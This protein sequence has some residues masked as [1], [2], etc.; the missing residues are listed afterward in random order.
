[1]H[2]IFTYFVHAMH[3]MEP[4]TI[5]IIDTDVV[6]YK[7]LPEAWDPYHSLSLSTLTH[8]LVY[9]TIYLY[10]TALLYVNTE[11]LYKETACLS[12]VIVYYT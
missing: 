7:I 5:I 1:M 3:T 8:I 10:Q 6:H 9:T 4:Y 2:N 12:Q 11:C